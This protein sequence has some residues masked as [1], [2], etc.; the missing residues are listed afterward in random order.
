MTQALK[1]S[2]EIITLQENI[3]SLKQE[4]GKVIFER[5]EMLNTVK[6]NLEAEYQKKIGYKELERMETEITARRY[7]RQVE[8]IRAA[9]NRQESIEENRIE[10]QLDDEFQEWYK[11]IKEQYQKVKEAED[12]LNSL[13]SDDQN[14][15]FKKLYRQLVFKL[16]PDLNPNQT[17]DEENLWHRVQ[18]A[19]EGGDLEEM[20]SLAIILDAQYETVELP[21]SKDVLQKR[22]EKLTEQIQKTINTMSELEQKF[23]FNIIGKLA[24]ND[25]VNTKVE[26]IQEQI[27]QWQEKC[28]HYEDLI[29]VLLVNKAAGVN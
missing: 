19:Y 8:L 10:K 12:R 28:K 1:L 23:P 16:H 29:K 13:M 25:W 18:L 14:K 2:P 22:K 3:A 20:R 27:N 11:K 26:E 15:E 7:K 4:L 21:S 24:D 5:D 6:P 9:V 17:K